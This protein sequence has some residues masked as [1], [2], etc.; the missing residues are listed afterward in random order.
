MKIADL[1][2]KKITVMGLGLHGGGV[3]IAKFLCDNGAIVTV[4]DIK[5]KEDLAPSIEKLKNC[6]NI[7]FVFN[8]HRPEDFCACDMVIKNPSAPWDN[9]YVK[10]ALEA[11]IPVESDS[12]LFFKFCKNEIIGITGTKGKTTAA[13]LVFE[14]MKAAGKPVMKVGIGQISVLD[15]IAEIKKDTIVVFELS[16]WRLSAL[17]RHKLSPKVAVITNIYPDHLN[18]YKTIEEYLDDKKYIF[19]NQEASDWCVINQDDAKL[20][21]LEL[22]IKS[23]IIK[24]S[25]TKIDSGRAVYADNGVV[26]LNNGIDEK[27]V[28]NIADI[29]IKGGHNRENVMAAIAA[30]SVYDIDPKII[31]KV[32]ENFSGVPHRLELIRELDG[33]KYINDTAATTP[34]SAIAALSSYSEPLVLICGGSDKNLDVANFGAEIVRKAKAVVFL[35]GAATEKIISAVKDNLPPLEKDKSFT[36]VDSMAKAVEMAR[37][38]AESGDIILL[39]PGAASFG[40]FVNE[41]DRGDKFKEAVKELK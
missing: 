38:G 10:M 28:I 26:Y 35:P 2:D 41:F 30:V 6:K 3:A 20:R 39:S 1:K 32:I 24:F 12:S 5:S 4:T 40:L 25:K 33:V 22:E 29:K 14:I 9:K 16:S 19:K 15:K 31:K 34:E 17:G 21:S 7:T 8:A 18:Y 36:I 13:T 37:A 23:Q 11:K 27:K